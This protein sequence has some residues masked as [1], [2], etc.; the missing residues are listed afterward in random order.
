MLLLLNCEFQVD[1]RIEPSLRDLVLQIAQVGSC[2]F[3]VTR[4]VENWCSFEH[5]QVNQAL[6]AA[7][8]NFLKEY[9]IFVTQMESDHARVNTKV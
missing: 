3:T 6:C 4:F 5:G 8:R 7:I 1:Q 9:L 2:Y